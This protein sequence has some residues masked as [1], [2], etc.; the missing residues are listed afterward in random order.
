[1]N[2]QLL[3]CQAAEVG[4]KSNCG[5]MES[6]LSRTIISYPSFQHQLEGM[7]GRNPSQAEVPAKG[8][9]SQLETVA[10]LCSISLP[11][12]TYLQKI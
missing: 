10:L 3:Y 6:Q 1:M 4:G 8:H 12:T 5:M 7:S 11:S 9:D 2:P